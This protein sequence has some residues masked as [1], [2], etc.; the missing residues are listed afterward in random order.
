M[1]EQI[2][3]LLEL[4]D[5]LENDNSSET[6]QKILSQIEQIKYEVEND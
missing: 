3:R 6:K 4:V 1:K 5:L 2:Y